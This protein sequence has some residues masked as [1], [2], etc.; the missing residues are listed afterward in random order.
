M[1]TW[2]KATISIFALLTLSG[3]ANAATV[4]GATKVRLVSAGPTWIQVGELQ[5]VETGT[6]NN[7]ALASNGAIAS[8]SSIFCQTCGP[9][10]AID[11]NTNT[12]YFTAPGIFH[13]GSPSGQ[14]FLE[15]DF[16]S[17]ANLSSL[18]IYGRSDYPVENF[19][20]QWIVSIFNGAGA[21][22][23][24][25][26]LGSIIT[27]GTPVT[28]NFDPFVGGG[29]PEP[30]TWALMIAGFGLVGASIR[31]RSKVTVTYA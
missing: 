16:A 2:T 25:G 24:S 5:A 10:K 8:A 14:E 26:N 20:D 21:T 18:T 30:A 19:R 6:G 12:D 11:G 27:P 31:R 9:D 7:V 1:K 4:I 13:S 23:Y 3:A 17:A 22:L 29:V 15:I 28:V